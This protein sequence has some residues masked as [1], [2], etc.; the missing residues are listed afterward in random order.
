MLNYST[1]RGLEG[2]II[3]TKYALISKS[4]QLQLVNLVYRRFIVY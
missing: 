1:L 2:Y 4:I 3:R